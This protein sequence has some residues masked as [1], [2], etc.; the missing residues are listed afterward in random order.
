MS[1]RFG[2]GHSVPAELFGPIVDTV[3]AF[4]GWEAGFILSPGAHEL[5]NRLGTGIAAADLIVRTNETPVPGRALYARGLYG[6]LTSSVIDVCP[7]SDSIA[8]FSISAATLQDAMAFIESTFDPRG[9]L[10]IYGNSAGGDC[11]LNL[12]RAITKCKHSYYWRED[13]TQSNY[14]GT[15]SNAD[16]QGDV[17]VDLLITVDA[18]AGPTS[19][20]LDRS[21][22]RCVNMNM[23]NF[24]TIAKADQQ[25]SRGAPQTADD[26]SLTYVANQ[27][28]SG[29]AD[30]YALGFT[31]LEHSL[32][33]INVLR[34]EGQS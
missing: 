10:I 30:H 6:V 31:T 16:V 27:D 12:C 14:L 4:S 15:W 32:G 7:P 2:E 3:V 23:N 13:P 26:P 28:F 29:V 22:P 19:D 11:A 25:Y 8:P 1:V 33:L 9:K 24:Q 18:A 34:A 20:L 17:R 5:P 21:V